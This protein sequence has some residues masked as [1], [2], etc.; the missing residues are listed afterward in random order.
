MSSR[1]TYANN[2]PLRY[3]DP[4]GCLTEE[5]INMWSGFTADFLKKYCPE[6]YHMLLALHLGDTLIAEIGGVLL[7]GVAWIGEGPYA[8]QFLTEDSSF[9]IG[10]LIGSYLQGGSG[11]TSLRLWRPNRTLTHWEL[12]Y[13]WEAGQDP[14]ASYQAYAQGPG[15][16][17]YEWTHTT[18][19]YEAALT[20]LLVTWPG[21]VSGIP[22]FIGGLA[23]GEG[24]FLQTPWAPPGVKEGDHTMIYKQGNWR[25]EVVVRGREVVKYKWNYV[26]YKGLSG[27]V[28]YRGHQ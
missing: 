7:E 21:L 22:G 11:I 20:T 28:P 10:D 14:E 24:G 19:W 25:L 1:Y 26:G 23:A 2:D 18:T 4:T 16:Y 5:E 12:V 17:D 6:L 9:S 3:T 27:K 13:S 15:H 8:L